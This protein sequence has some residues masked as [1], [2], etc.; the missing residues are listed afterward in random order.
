MGRKHY[1]DMDLVGGTAGTGEN[2]G[3]VPMT[4]SSLYEGTLDQDMAAGK[5]EV[6]YISPPRVRDKMPEY[7]GAR[8]MPS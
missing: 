3:Y 8:H 6:T 1:W 7:R 4:I 2:L 5:T